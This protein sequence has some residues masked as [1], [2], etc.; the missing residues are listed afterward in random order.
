MEV[1]V[2]TAQLTLVAYILH[3]LELADSNRAL[4]WIPLPD[5]SGKAYDHLSRT[6]QGSAIPNTEPVPF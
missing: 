4:S 6:H 3:Q 5:V 2:D 1:N